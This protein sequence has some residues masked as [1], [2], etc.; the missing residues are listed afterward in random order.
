[1][2]LRRASTCSRAE[3]V[4]MIS[5]FDSVCE[6]VTRRNCR[7][8]ILK[9]VDDEHVVVTTLPHSSFGDSDCCGCLN[10][11]IRGDQADIV[12]N[13]CQTVVRSLPTA[14]LRHTLNEM[15]LALDNCTEMCPYCRSVNV[16]PGLSRVMVFTCRGCRQVVRL[17][18]DSDTER[19]FLG[20]T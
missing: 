2:G 11:I 19:F 9:D 8:A 20:K 5:C 15:E 17:T 13:D 14:A 10:G 1:M 4:V 12:C 18:D 3:K 6:T 16:I 7:I